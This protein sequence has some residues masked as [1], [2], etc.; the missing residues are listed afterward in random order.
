[1]STLTVKELS[2]PAGEVLKIS[3][4]KV[5]DL[6]S[7]G[8]VTMPTGSLL[9]TVQTGAFSRLTI[10]STGS[11][12]STGNTL[13][14]TPS[15]TSSKVLISITQPIAVAGSTPMRG[16]LRLLRNGVVVWNTDGFQEHIQVRNADNEHHAVVTIVHLDSP[17]SSSAVTYTLY[18]YLLTGTH[19]YA[20]ES[21]KGAAMLLQEIQG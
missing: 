6:K 4:G 19:F 18:A 13:A 17:S 10:T 16:G 14:I 8:T 11:W 2:H 21:S 20:F 1:M 15:S 5:L 9:Q 7:Q 12:V 3:A